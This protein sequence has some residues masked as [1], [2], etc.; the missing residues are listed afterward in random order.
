MD[1]ELMDPDTEFANAFNEEEGERTGGGESINEEVAEDAA[2][3]AG[4]SG[5]GAPADTGVA[6]VLN[7][8][9]AADGQAAEGQ[10]QGA[11]DLEKEMQRLKSWEGRLKAREAELEGKASKAGGEERD[12]QAADALEDVAAT[13]DAKG[14]S[15]LA[16]AANAAAEAVEAGEITPEQ[17]VAQL[18]EDFGEEF[19]KMIQAIVVA[20]TKK[21]VE[22]VTKTVDEVIS[23]INSKEKRAHF[24]AIASKHPD[25]ADVGK[26]DTFKAYIQSL[27]DS[28]RAEAERVAKGGAAE[29]VISLLDAYKG[30]QA[31]PKADDPKPAAADTSGG[32]D[33]GLEDLEGVRSGG[34]RLPEKP[35]PGND[36]YAGAWDQF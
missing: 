4:Q 33:G 35:T 20:T 29:E 18:S 17:A 21:E 27:P 2:G 11:V 15:E 34:V 5:G 23:N 12:E 19:I 36:D 32:D 9:Q 10:G 26:S 3:D 7:N 6:V 16:D 8:D 24:K 28:E 22:P 13:A 14:S 1:P 25:F 31:K 30:S